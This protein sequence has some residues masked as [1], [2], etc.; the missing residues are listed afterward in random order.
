MCNPCLRPW[1][2][3]RGLWATII[4]AYNVYLGY[5]IF[6]FNVY[7]NS[8]EKNQCWQW[9]QGLGFVLVLTGLVYMYLLMMYGFKATTKW[10]KALKDKYITK[11]PSPPTKLPKQAQ[12][13]ITY[14]FVFISIGVFL[15]VDTADDRR[16]LISAA[17]IVI[18]VI[19]LAL[20]SKHPKEINWRQV[21]NW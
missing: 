3:R 6:Y 2:L 16:R 10:R 21:R 8:E 4:L 17:G 20:L 5:A 7:N 9:C 19:L 18:L 14:G 11:I 15:A 1:L 12:I 13:A